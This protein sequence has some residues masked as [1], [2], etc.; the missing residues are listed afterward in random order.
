[1][2]LVAYLVLFM[3]KL[4]RNGP[5]VTM[6]VI[7]YQCKVLEQFTQVKISSDSSS[8]SDI[9]NIRKLVWNGNGVMVYTHIHTLTH[10]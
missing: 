8:L 1:M 4:G 10:I 3:R 5:S 2:F 7:A 9:C 6:I